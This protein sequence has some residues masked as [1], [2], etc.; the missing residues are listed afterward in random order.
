MNVHNNH[1]LPNKGIRPSSTN[2]TRNPTNGFHTREDISLAAENWRGYVF[3]TPYNC[4][5]QSSRLSI[6]MLLGP[7]RYTTILNE[8]H[9]HGARLGSRSRVSSDLL[10]VVLSKHQAHHGPPT[11]IHSRG[12]STWQNS[13]AV[14]VSVYL[15]IRGLN[16]KVDKSRVLSSFLMSLMCFFGV[17]TTRR[18]RPHPHPAQK[19]G[20]NRT[21]PTRNRH[22]QISHFAFRMQRCRVQG[23][24]CR[25]QSAEHREKSAECSVQQ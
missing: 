4:H 1:S 22:S 13:A 24:Q 12:E 6:V 19:P 3:G 5:L 10:S 11:S 18:D 20:G 2:T 17:S 16:A 14:V 8:S 15:V 9:I 23:V 25:E 7:L 21:E